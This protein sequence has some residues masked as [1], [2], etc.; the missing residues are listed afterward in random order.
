MGCC[1]KTV[2]TAKHIAIGYAN[3][4][5]GKK[6]EFTDGRIRACRKCDD[7]FW[8]GRNLFCLLRLRRFGRTLWADPNAFVPTFAA[9]KKNE[10]LKDRW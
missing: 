3:L 8:I 10:C 5:V 2:K 9:D 1:G 6:Y 4:V 7:N